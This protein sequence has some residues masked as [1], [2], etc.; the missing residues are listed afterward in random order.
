MYDLTFAPGSSFMRPPSQNGRM[1]MNNKELD[2]DR[3][4]KFVWMD[5]DELREVPQ[6]K[7]RSMA[8]EARPGPDNDQ[9]KKEQGGDDTGRS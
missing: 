4:S 2:R 7:S 3:R 8:V 1:R 5:L 6:K 9:M